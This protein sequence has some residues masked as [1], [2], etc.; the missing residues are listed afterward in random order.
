MVKYRR[1]Q[2]A[3]GTYFFTATLHDRRANTLTAH[4]DA[5]RNALR[6]TQEHRPFDIDA[7]VVLPDHI[8]TIWTLPE[9]D[10][11]YSGR[12]RMFKSLFVRNLTRN[13]VG[14]ESPT[15]VWQARFWEHLIRDNLDFQN[16]IDYVHFN[17]VKHGH[18]KRVCDWPWS[19]FHRYVKQGILPIDWAGSGVSDHCVRY[20]E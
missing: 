5:L 15:Q 8:H 13:P 19:S 3:G 18:V 7:V 6:Q 16:H 2:L 12:W 20:G 4:I 11:D 17:P 1:I 14:S 9:A 10:A